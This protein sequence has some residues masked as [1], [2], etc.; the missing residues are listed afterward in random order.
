MAAYFENNSVSTLRIW[1]HYIQNFFTGFH[2][3]TMREQRCT[4]KKKTRQIVFWPIC[5]PDKS[6]DKWKK[7]KCPNLKLLKRS[8]FFSVTLLVSQ[9]FLQS[10]L[11]NKLSICWIHYTICLTT[12]LMIMTF[13]KLKP[14][15]MPTWSCLEFQKGAITMRLKFLEWHWIFWQR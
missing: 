2:L 7:G 1:I 6:W 10:Q 4:D 14:L 13:T 8:Q 9:R 12:E 11:R 3:Y 5:S 15:V